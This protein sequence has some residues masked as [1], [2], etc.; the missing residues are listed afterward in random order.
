MVR[1]EITTVRLRQPGESP[2][3][4][5][6][7]FTAAQRELSARKDLPTYLIR[8][9]VTSSTPGS[10]LQTVLAVGLAV[11]LGLLVWQGV[12]YQRRWN[13]APAVEGDVI[14]VKPPPPDPFPS[15]YTI[16]YR[17]QAGAAHRAV[18]K[19]ADVYA[20]PHVGEKLEIRYLPE[21]PDRPMGPA[22]YRDAAF[23]KYIPWGIGIMAT[24]CVL[25]IIIPV[26]GWML[27]GRR[28]PD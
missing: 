27:R 18:L 14:D 5:L 26:A 4:G 6:G 19:W 3:R 12:D 21:A 13:A 2:R 22:R 16:A 7:T 10:W 15:E 28:R 9:P 24:Y 25:L 1:G 11:A 23:E 8:R 17:D 20:T